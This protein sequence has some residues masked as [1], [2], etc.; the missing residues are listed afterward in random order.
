MTYIFWKNNSF[1]SHFFLKPLK[2]FKAFNFPLPIS[3]YL[4]YRIFFSFQLSE[5]F[6]RLV[7]FDIFQRLSENLAL[8]SKSILTVKSVNHKGKMEILNA[9]I[10]LA[11]RQE[12]KECKLITGFFCHWCCVKGERIK[13]LV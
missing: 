12:E 9:K 2:L 3:P 6:K 7:E 10:A 4:F 5:E 11:R 8:Y 1:L 13:F